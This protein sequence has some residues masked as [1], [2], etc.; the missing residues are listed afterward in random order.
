L[1]PLHGVHQAQNAAVALAAVEA[2]FGIWDGS[3]QIEVD[4]IHSGFAEARSPGRLE[5][6]RTAPTILLDAAHN[7]PGMVAL[8]AAIGEEFSFD[9]LVAVVGVLTDKDAEGMLR[10]LEPRVDVLVCTQSSSPRARPADDLARLASD[11][12]GESRVLVVPSVV[13]ALGTA[14]GLAVAGVDDPT[15]AGVLVTGSVTTVGEAR[16]VLVTED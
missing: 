6:I 3:R 7:V 13:D 8:T 11:I 15:G 10:L 5:R 16:R 2:F 4:V 1:L 9:R 14:I 12:L